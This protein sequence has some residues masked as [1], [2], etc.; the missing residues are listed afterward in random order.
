[1]NI[2]DRILRR[3]RSAYKLREKRTASR[4]LNKL[5]SSPPVF[6]LGSQ[7]SGSTVIAASLAKAT[8]C[9][10]TLDIRRA[11][12]DFSWQPLTALGVSPLSDF[13]Y[14]YRREFSREIVKEPALSFFFD[15]LYK[16]FPNA[17]FVMIQR[18]PGET[19][20]SILNRLN[21]QGDLENI[22]F[23][24]WPALRQ[25]PVWRLALDSAWL[26]RPS[27][28]YVEALAIRWDYIAKTY[29]A[30]ADRFTLI[31]YEDFLKDKEGEILNLARRLGLSVQHNINQELQRQYQPRGQSVD[32]R[33][34]FGADNY[35]RIRSVCEG[36]ARYLGYEL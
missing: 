21:I 9:S 6:V 16:L 7:K 24:D 27:T 10:V 29:L 8:G 36:R 31:R 19:I 5:A 26:D 11:I 12:P 1:M 23:D 35:D 28:N 33:E 20:R 3:I 17:A 13:V 30:A 14:R 22:C 18:H 32:L 34:F 15:G 2:T 25:S 4:A